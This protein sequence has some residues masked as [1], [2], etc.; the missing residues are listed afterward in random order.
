MKPFLL[1]E[2]GLLEEVAGL[3]RQAGIAHGPWGILSHQIARTPW[4]SFWV[5][6]KLG[7]DLKWFLL[8]QDVTI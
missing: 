1:K 3:R 4:M 7:A 6:H 5:C 2:I 8:A